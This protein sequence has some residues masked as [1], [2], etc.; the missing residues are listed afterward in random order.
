[1]IVAHRSRH[2][3]RRVMYGGKAKTFGVWLSRSLTVVTGGLVVITVVAFAFG[4]MIEEA[5]RGLVSGRENPLVAAQANLDSVTEL[6]DEATAANRELKSEW[7]EALAALETKAKQAGNSTV[8]QDWVTSRRHVQRLDAALRWKKKLSERYLEDLARLEELREDVNDIR[9]NITR[10]NEGRQEMRRWLAVIL[11]GICG[12]GHLFHWVGVFRQR[13]AVAA[14]CPQ[15]LS[16]G[17]LVPSE[18]PPKGMWE[19]SSDDEIEGSCDL[20][21]WERYRRMTKIGFPTLGIPSSGKTHWLAMVYR[22]ISLGSYPA[23]AIIRPID[24]PTTD[25]FDYRV[26][27]ILDGDG[28]TATDYARLPR[29]LPFEFQDVDPWGNSEVM[30]H[31]FDLAGETIQRDISNPRVV[32]ALKAHGFLF[33]LD[34][35]DE[36]GVQAQMKALQKFRDGVANVIGPRLKIPVALCV[37]KI[38]Q[39]PNQQF[40]K[41]GSIDQ[42]YEDIRKVG[43]TFSLEAMEKRSRIVSRLRETMWP[44]WEI[45]KEVG[46]IFGGR[47]LFFPLTPVGLENIGEKDLKKVT[48][49]PFAIQ[50]PLFWLLHMSG[51]PV[52]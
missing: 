40:G 18:P 10:Q 25:D 39:L 36:A 37:S 23:K 51:Y 44:G 14:M 31:I 9:G 21:L 35:T 42:F 32:R 22:Q 49:R 52:F 17:S 8:L 16:S 12:G 45:E 26:A 2:Q 15:C 24:S 50:E 19:C 34:P 38:D 13:A 29:G 46:K 3:F 4:P 11:F 48:A 5:V 28:T 20:K 1:V 41:G 43:L 30:V 47:H 33:F 7:A 27:G 6:L